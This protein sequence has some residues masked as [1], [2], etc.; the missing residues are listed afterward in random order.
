MEAVAIT[1]LETLYGAHREEVVKEVSVVD[2][3]V[4]EIFRFH[5]HTPW[6]PMD[7]FRQGLTGMTL[8]FLFYNNPG[9]KRS[10]GNLCKSIL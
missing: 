2:E 10:N 6:S 1:D 7:Q 4:Q 8:Y 3:Y 9:P 5:P